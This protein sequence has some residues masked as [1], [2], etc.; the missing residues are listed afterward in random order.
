MLQTI[1]AEIR[2]GHIEPL[3]EIALPEGMRVLV[4]VLPSD[5]R[6]FWLTASQSSLEKVWA[7]EEDD[8]YAKL[9]KE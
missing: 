2:N 3:E 4:T 5:D 8:V 1:V 6:E 9:L 7:N